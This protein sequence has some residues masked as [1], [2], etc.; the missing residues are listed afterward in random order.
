MYKYCKSDVDI[1]RRGCIELR[2]LFLE[3]S[4]I[5]PF[6]YI[7]IASVCMAIYK[8][9]FL[10]EKTIGVMKETQPD[11]YSFKSIKW[12][13]YLESTNYIKIQHALNGKEVKIKINGQ[14]YKVDGYCKETNT[15][16]QFHGCY[17]HGCKECYDPLTLNKLNNRNM[18]LLY[19][20]THD[21]DN[22]L[23]KVCNLNTIWEHEFDKNIAMTSIKLNN[24]DLVEPPK[25]RDCF[26]GGRTEPTKLIYNFKKHNQKGRYID[27]CSLYPTVMYY[28]KYPTGHPKKIIRPETYD[29]DW[30]GFIHCKVLPPKELYHPVL[31]YKQKIQGAH[32]L[33]F[34][35]CKSCMNRIDIKCAHDIKTREKC[36]NC[37]K[38]RE[39]T[40]SKTKKCSECKYKSNN[41]KECYEIRNSKCNH[42]DSERE[43]I[44]FWTTV[45]MNKAIEK[46]YK[47]TNIY[48]VWNF[49]QSSTELFKGYIRKFMKIKMESSEFKCSEEEYRDSARK[50]G[51]ELGELKPNPGLRFIAKL[52]LNSLWGK[53][54]QNPKMLKKEYIN[55]ESDF[56]KLILN[57]KI[58]NIAISFLK[59][60]NILYI[61]YDEKNEFIKQNY[62]TSIYIAC[63]TS[64][65]ARLRLYDMLDKIGEKVCYY[66]T[67]SI[68]YAED[69]TN[70]HIFKN[71]G[72][73]L[74]EWTNELKDNHIEYWSCSC[75]KDYGYIK[76]NGKYTGKVK[77]FRITAETEN[78][79]NFENRI[80]L[81]NGSIHNIPINYFQFKIENKQIFTHNL[82]KDWSFQF[83]KRRIVK[84]CNDEID[85]LP[86]GY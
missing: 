53:F 28:D 4:G 10:P 75:P 50:L 43:I 66:D 49:E 65:H 35:L 51:I 18:Y 29:K 20:K 74:G 77:G 24:D 8:N 83:N 72:D 44:G 60:D 73:S 31:P 84:V 2:K 64:A 76:D 21:I 78:K 57:D 39:N 45:E 56:Y 17:F 36:N 27:V 86:F 3:I 15:I 12:M 1:L 32:K 38:L 71:I 34:G 82:T 26:Y 58:E 69:D 85:T 42:L 23:R 9:E 81:I 25:I 30:F 48:E 59:N 47:I 22:T 67:D 11:T 63:F 6:Q 68:V 46:G 37:I 54:G 62:N 52:C 40:K 33:L 13:K 41:C 16:Y 61:T 19:N 7:T 14:I 80:N 5:D 55:N 70:K 79:M